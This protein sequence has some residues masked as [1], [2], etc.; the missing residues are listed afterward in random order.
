MQFVDV[1]HPRGRVG[2][3]AGRRGLMLTLTRCGL[4]H[5][6]PA[7]AGYALSARRIHSECDLE[8]VR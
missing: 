3:L 6:D 1:D 2:E 7:E 5:K 8:S 4:G